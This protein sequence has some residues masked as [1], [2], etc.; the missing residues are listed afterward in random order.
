[1][2]CLSCQA[3]RQQGRLP[4]LWWGKQR[5]LRYEARGRQG[6]T[7]NDTAAQQS[8]LKEELQCKGGVVINQGFAACFCNRVQPVCLTAGPR[9]SETV[10]NDQ[11][12]R[13]LFPGA[14]YSV[15]REQHPTVR[16]QHEPA[17]SLQLCCIDQHCIT[18]N[19]LLP[20]LWRCAAFRSI[21]PRA[22]HRAPPTMAG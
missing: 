11:E 4:A 3:V 22:P 2:L 1:M 5:E 21:S 19:L 15:A 13:Y 8:R 14:M 10:A 18:D 9:C 12:S 17:A 6:R 7:T 16:T 20:L